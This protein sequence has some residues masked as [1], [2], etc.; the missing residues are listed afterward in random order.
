MDIV[1][2]DAVNVVLSEAV[3]VVVVVAVTVNMQIMGQSL[4]LTFIQKKALGIMASNMLRG[5]R[6]RVGGR[7]KM[8]GTERFTDLGKAKF[9]DGGSVFGS[10]LFSIMPQLP[11]KY[12]SIQKRSK[13]TQK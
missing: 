6:E 2:F 11:Q 13:S 1:V 4:C 8:R 9:L 10:S 5:K 12:C 3:A 7:E